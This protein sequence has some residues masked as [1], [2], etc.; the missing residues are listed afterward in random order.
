MNTK[1]RF[2]VAEQFAAGWIS[3]WNSRDLDAIMHHYASELSFCSPLIL[4]LLPESDGVISDL[5][6]LRHYFS[7][8]LARAPELTFELTGVLCGVRGFMLTYINA[9]GGDTAEYIELDKEGKAN[10]VVVCYSARPS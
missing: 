5:E 7:T 1:I 6:E 10:V 2:E 8:G 4:K 3:A 9:R